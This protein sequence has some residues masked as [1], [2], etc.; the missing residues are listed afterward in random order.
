MGLQA[1]IDK[2][3]ETIKTDGYSMSI[4]ELISIYKEDEIDIHP[5]FQRFFRWSNAQKTRFIES[6][7]LGI[8]IPPIF[9]SQ[10]PDGVWDVID[11]LQRLATIFEFVGILKGEDKETVPP[12]VLEG[13]DYPNRWYLPSLQSTVWD[14]EIASRISAAKSDDC[15][16]TSFTP[17]QRVLIKRAKIQ[18]SI[19]LEETTGKSKY[20]L[21]QRLNTGGTNLSYQ[22]VRNCMLIMANR[23]MYDWMKK[24]AG[25][26][27]FQLC[28][29]ITE[30]NRQEQYDLELVLRFLA[31]RNLSQERVGNMNEFM[32]EEMIQMAEAKEFDYE[33]KER[34][35]KQTFEILAN[36][37]G[38][39]SFRRY[40]HNKQKFT[41]RFLIAAF[42]TIAPGIGYNYEQL[43]LDYSTIAETIKKLWKN[44]TFVQCIQGGQ[45]A[46]T[47]IPKLIPL[48][49][50]FFSHGKHSDS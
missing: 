32:T 15:Q 17:A 16:V 38:D 10:R 18:V 6:V 44:E 46:S 20:E 28:T 31:L 29:P 43:Y 19:I 7:L 24:L 9:V 4:G 30:R 12:L 23:K 13:V 34:A 2:A 26:D 33:G 22:E 37:T 42:E 39:D 14:E 8:P 5:E 48:G 25:D 11:G 41:G 50:K 49:R 3:R 1:E 40:D 47:R 21:F 27:N 35:F 45:N 36:V